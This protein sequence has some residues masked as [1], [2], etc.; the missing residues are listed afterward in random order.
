MNDNP[1][2]PAACDLVA[3]GSGKGGK[4]MAWTEEDQRQLDLPSEALD[5][6]TRQHMNHWRGGILGAIPNLDGHPRTSE[7]EP[8]PDYRAKSNVRCQQWISDTCLEPHDQDRIDY[9]VEIAARQTALQ[10]N[11]VKGVRSTPWVPL[12]H[13]IAFLAA[14]NETIKPYLAAKENSEVE[15]EK[16][17]RAWCKST[18]LQLALWARPDTEARH[19]LNEW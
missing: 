11:K 6:P 12:R 10:K 13:T 9:Q 3:L 7:G 17:P 1:S 5:H 8:L 18:Q 4:P 15:V 19:G 16:M 14:I 2:K